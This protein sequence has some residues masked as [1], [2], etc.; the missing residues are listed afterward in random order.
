MKPPT[1][2]D[3]SFAGQ[4]SLVRLLLTGLAATLATGLGMVVGFFGGGLLDQVLGYPMGR[5]DGFLP[6]GFLSVTV[7]LVATPMG[8]VIG[9]IASHTWLGGRGSPFWV[10]IGAVILAIGGVALLSLPGRGLAL[11]SLE[12]PQP[13]PLLVA[14]LPC[15]VYP[16]SR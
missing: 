8:T 2:R 7:L 6:M 13:L 12:A 9:A 11:P 16:L 1:P 3:T 4:F 5:S 10:P 15:H 14:L